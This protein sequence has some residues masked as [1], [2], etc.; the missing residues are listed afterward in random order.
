MRVLRNCLFAAVAILATANAAQ[1]LPISFSDTFNPAV[2]RFDNIGGS[3]ADCVGINGVA[4]SI[5]GQVGGVCETLSYTHVLQPTY[6]PL[7]DTLASAILSIYV[8]DDESDPAAEK[9]DYAF[10]SASLEGFF[11]AV[12]LDG[13]TSGSPFVFP[14]DVLLKVAPDGTIDVRLELKAGDLMFLKSELIA[15]GDREEPNVPEAQL[16][17]PATLA[18]LG[19]A[20]AASIGR[21]R[22]A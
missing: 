22:F 8:Y 2:Q 4:D 3:D 17:E 15:R 5:T 9:M 6:V 11:P 1:A 7:T 20:A 19:L 13:S 16:P 12:S 10:D 18:L 21:K 14:V